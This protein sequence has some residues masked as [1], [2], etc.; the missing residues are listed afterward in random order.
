MNQ[1][2][3]CS[4][5]G[6]SFTMETD[7]YE[8]LSAYIE[9]L[10]NN[11]K[12]D[13][14]GEE[15]VGDI[16]ARIA[17]LI[18]SAQKADAIICKPLI[19]NIIKQLGST[20]EINNDSPEYEQ[21]KR[22]PE[23][24]DS[25]GIPRMPRRLYRDMESGKL[26]GVCAGIANYFDKDV[27]LIRLLMFVPLI[28]SVMS[29]PL[30]I[31][32]WFEPMMWNVFIVELICYL[33]MWFT[34]PVASSAR[35][36]LEMR[37]EKIT[38]QSIR[39]NTST[40]ADARERSIIA[41]IVGAIGTILLIGLKFLALL[42]LIGLVVG[43]SLLGMVALSAVPMFGFEFYTGLAL[44]SFFFVA[45]LPIVALIYLAIMF[46]ISRRPKGLIFLVILMMWIVA[47]VTMTISAIKSPSTFGNSVKNAFEAV[48][49]HNQRKLYDEF[50][51]EEVE[52]YIKSG[53]F[54]FEIN[55]SMEATKSTSYS[56]KHGLISSHYSKG[57]MIVFCGDQ[58]G[59]KAAKESLLM[60]QQSKEISFRSMR[61]TAVTLS[62]KKLATE[63]LNV[64]VLKEQISESA[65][66]YAF[67]VDGD[68]KVYCVIG[69]QV[70]DL[71]DKELIEEV[72]GV[73]GDAFNI[74]GEAFNLVGEV[75][76]AVGTA[77][78]T[79]GN[80]A[81]MKAH[82]KALKSHEKALEK[83]AKEIEEKAELIEKKM[84]ESK[85][86]YGTE[87]VEN[88][89]HFFT[90]GNE[91]AS[92]HYNG[93]G[94]M[95][96]MFCG[97]DK[98]VKGCEESLLFNS[99]HLTFVTPKGKKV[100]ASKDGIKVNG[101]E[102]NPV[103]KS[104]T[105]VNQQIRTA[106]YIFSVNGVKV[107]FQQ[108]PDIDMSE[109]TEEL[110][111]NI[112]GTT[113]KIFDA[114]GNIISAAGDIIS[115][116]GKAIG[117]QKNVEISYQRPKNTAI[118]KDILAQAKLSEPNK[119]A[120]TA[121]KIGTEAW[122]TN[123]KVYHY[124]LKGNVVKGYS[125]DGVYI[126]FYGSEKDVDCCIRHFAIDQN[127][128]VQTTTRKGNKFLIT[129]YGIKSL[130]ESSKNKVVEIER[131]A[132]VRGESEFGEQN[133][134]MGKFDDVEYRYLIG[135]SDSPVMKENI[136]KISE[137]SYIQEQFPQKNS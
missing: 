38:A 123:P 127:G 133:L 20:E 30:A 98:I 11:Y 46:L 106:T 137:T 49:D 48:F 13:P 121:T 45:I 42:I 40:T 50:E 79:G 131:Y 33:V 70:K 60:D 8:A 118:Y 2:K 82:E 18:L 17:E 94:K 90:I 25:N 78:S 37:G 22:E 9:S 109:V 7:A 93:K 136:A 113:S 26:G 115:T 28:L 135:P 10:K 111:R 61:G 16:E 129:K 12:N 62:P 97:D 19:D 1:I 5:A 85:R 54:V 63:S 71:A 86:A 35:Q 24:T 91:R 88:M 132:E 130:F 110:V 128:Y 69:E 101:K 31:F 120:T 4:I 74:T 57:M 100:T 105:K 112:F 114:A 21:P 65:A 3:K 32:R 92:S 47:L 44:M 76:K 34:V 124:P 116:A 41:K 81:A 67:K 117:F 102:H 89:T 99:D 27:T 72:F 68:L 29:G 122:A 59:V 66:A 53:K 107:H 56:T 36:K 64:E 87:G 75:V 119:G 43:C 96:I 39:E 95:H 77:I 103:V 73:A 83:S 108:G 52:K 55:D 80:E 134:L 15:I 104:Y 125:H 23:I 51:E 126:L 84:E 58:H 14:D 6:V